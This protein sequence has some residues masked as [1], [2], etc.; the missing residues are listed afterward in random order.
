M[1]LLGFNFNI[2][3]VIPNI[4]K[5]EWLRKNTETYCSRRQVES[6][7]GAPSPLAFP[8]KAVSSGFKVVFPMEISTSGTN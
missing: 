2:T 7:K 8:R 1:L 4:E 6:F 5:A 3:L